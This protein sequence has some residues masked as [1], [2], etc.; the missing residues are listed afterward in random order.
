M[1]KEGE[2][3]GRRR[4]RKRREDMRKDEKHLENL[5]LRERKDG[6]RERLNMTHGFTQF[7]AEVC[8]TTEFQMLLCSCV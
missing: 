5:G 4:E 3:D 7:I 8:T 6:E 1:E 2:R